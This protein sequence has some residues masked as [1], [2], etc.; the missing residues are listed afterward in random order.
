MTRR[1]ALL[2]TMLVAL[3]CFGLVFEFLALQLRSG[4]DP[5]LS[6][7]SSSVPAKLRPRKELIITRV[8]SDGGGSASQTTSSAGA[9]SATPAPVTTSTS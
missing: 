9:V 7:A 3:V 2:P 8:I 6:A 5:A 4:R 1:S